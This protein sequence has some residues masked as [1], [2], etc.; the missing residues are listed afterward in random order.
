MSAGAGEARFDIPDLAT[1]IPKGMS[2][3]RAAQPWPRAVAIARSLNRQLYY[4]GAGVLR[5]RVRPRRP[6]ATFRSGDQRRANITS[7]VT[8]SPD[9]TAIANTVWFRGG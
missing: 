9:F 4:D 1:R 7:P 3:G 5:L 6:V 8:V 2:L